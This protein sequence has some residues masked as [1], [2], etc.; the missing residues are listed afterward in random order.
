MQAFCYAEGT[1]AAY[2]M[3]VRM[4]HPEREYL[5]KATRESVRFGMQMQYNRL[6]TYAFTRPSEMLGG[7]RYAMNETKV[8][9]DYVY[10]AQ[11]A[12]V[13][14][15]HAAL[16]DDKLPASVTNGTPL[17]WQL[18]KEKPV[19]SFLVLPESSESSVPE[20]K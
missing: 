16:K 10:H 17:P 7:T 1:A 18:N 11:S 9:I 5:E 14:W 15:Y 6:N 20:D 12:M 8:R 2:A 19:P 13:Q 3:A 4:D